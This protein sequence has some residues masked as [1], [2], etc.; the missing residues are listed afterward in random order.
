VAPRRAR[1]IERALAGKGFEKDPTHHLMFWLH[2]DGKKTSVRTRLSHGLSEYGDSLLAQ[3][4]K[5]MKITRAQLDAFID[6]DL[7]AAEYVGVLRA[8]GHV[9]A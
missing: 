5:Q 9:K 6:C 7:S 8:G 4:A 2:V 1:D 3:V